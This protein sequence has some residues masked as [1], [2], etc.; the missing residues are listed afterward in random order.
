[1]IISEMLANISLIYTEILRQEDYLEIYY[2]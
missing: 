2:N 1:M